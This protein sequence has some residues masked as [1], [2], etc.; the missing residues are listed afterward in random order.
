MNS[1][2][3]ACHCCGLI[4]EVPDLG[5]SETAQC[6]R[7]HAV[8]GR[9]GGGRAAA[10]RTAATALAALILFGPAILLP[11]LEIER[12]GHRHQS[13]VLGGI[14]DLLTHGSWFVGLIVLVFSIVFPLLKI[15][16]LL[17]LSL[18]GLLHRR[19]QA[20]TYRV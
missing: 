10:Q 6:V 14:I 12:L 5:P 11:I 20:L 4:H 1:T 16:M 17:E 8:I 15:G 19:H 7:C 3:K 9:F 2:K 18:L 13:S